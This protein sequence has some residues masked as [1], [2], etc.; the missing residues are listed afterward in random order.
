MYAL[1]GTHGEYLKEV[2]HNGIHRETAAF[3]MIPENPEYRRLWTTLCCA[4]YHAI[5][6]KVLETAIGEKIMLKKAVEQVKS[7]YLV[8]FR[9][10]GQTASEQIRQDI[11]VK[12]GT[13][14]YPYR[15][16]KNTGVVSS[17]WMRVVKL[18]E[19]EMDI[20]LYSEKEPETLRFFQKMDRTVQYIKN[21]D[22]AAL[23]R[24]CE[25]I[26]YRAMECLMRKIEEG[27]Q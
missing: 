9:L 26:A 4:V 6:L 18:S 8:L 2:L 1:Y 5:G 7:L 24:S 12:D 16:I 15:K 21:C 14:T 23:Q 22:G 13:E 3:F 10:D 25:Q 11:Y 17:S 20:F 19:E 27:N